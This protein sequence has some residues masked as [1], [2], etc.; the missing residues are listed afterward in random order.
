[1]RICVFGAGAVGGHFAARLHAGGHDVSV[2]ARGETLAAIRR[3]GLTLISDD[4]TVRAGVI[5]SDDTARLGRQDLV[6]STLKAHQLPALAAMIA[7]LLGA[8]TP[9]IFAQN[10]IAWWCDDAVS[11][12]LDPAGELHRAVGIRRVLGGVIQSA[13]ETVA[14]GVIVNRSPERNRLSI[15]EV[16]GADT[17]RIAV[18]RR[19]L[20][21]SGIDSPDVTDLPAAIWTKLIANLSVSVP[22]FLVERTSREVF[23]DPALSRIAEDI[24]N[25]MIAVARA[26]GVTCDAARPPP[27]SGHMSSML[28]DYRRGRALETA[29]LIDAPLILARARGIATPVTDTI[30]ALVRHKIATVASFQPGNHRA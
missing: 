26:H 17:A 8:E 12:L 5:A 28:Q 14:P 29:A 10:G 15:A 23:D 22:A 2:V 3:N 7:P 27:A 16:D 13:N 1:M 9:V 30:A 18:I 19:S 4:F 21:A 11:T 24:A 6:I 20:R 25:E